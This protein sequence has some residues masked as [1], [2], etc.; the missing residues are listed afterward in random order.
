[1]N[2]LNVVNIY[3]QQSTEKH[4]ST[5]LKE[6]LFVRMT[7]V[8]SKF[9]RTN[10]RT[11]VSRIKKAQLYCANWNTGKCCGVVFNIKKNREEGYKYLTNQRLDEKIASKD[12]IV[13]KGCAYYKNFVQPG[14]VEK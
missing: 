13:E 7:N 9:Y 4:N 3:I 8:I 6:D 12:C 11:F 5:H 10:C 2:V 1:M 14:L